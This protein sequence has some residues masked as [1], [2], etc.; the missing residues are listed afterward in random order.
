[1]V[2]KV[3]N[4]D[5]KL[6]VK[7]SWPENQ[8]QNDTWGHVSENNKLTPVPSNTNYHLDYTEPAGDLNIKLKD[9]A[10]FIQMNLQGLAGKDNYLSSENY[11]FIHKGIP[12]YS[13]GW[14]SSFENEKDFSTHS[15]TA[16]TYYTLVAIDRKKHIGYIIFTNAFNEETIKGVRMLMRKLKENYG[17]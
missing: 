8:K 1:L 17:S 2:E 12:N 11:T 7:F 9:Y 5:L 3:F 14:Y 10:K 15:G 13:L 16:G 6:D 4:A